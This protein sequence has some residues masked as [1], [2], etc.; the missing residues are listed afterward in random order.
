MSHDATSS[1]LVAGCPGVWWAR[2]L[3]AVVLAGSAATT[4]SAQQYPVTSGDPRIGLAAG[5]TDAEAGKVSLGLQHLS[6]TPK[7]TAVSGTNSDMAFQGNYAFIG[8][9]NGVNIYNIANPAA[10]ALVTAIS[11]P[12]ARTT[13]RCTSNLLFVSVESDGREEGLHRSTP[14]AD[15]RDALPRHPHLRHLRHQQPARIQVDG[16]PDVPRLAHAHAA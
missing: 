7:P 14:A 11:A 13:C 10:P 4:A 15:R 12:A 16:V 3:G 9:F 8:N 5:V 2:V 1:V 6:N